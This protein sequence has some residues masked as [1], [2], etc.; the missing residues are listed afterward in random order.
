MAANFCG[1]PSSAQAVVGN[2]SV[3]NSGGA[4]FL[5]LFPGNLTKA[6]LVATSN[7]PTPATFGDN[8]HY[9]VGLSPVDGTFKILF[10]VRPHQ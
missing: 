1:L 7:Y 6:P 2:V 8:R 3:V 4:G 9:F 5:T 10:C